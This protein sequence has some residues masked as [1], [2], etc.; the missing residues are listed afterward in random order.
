VVLHRIDLLERLHVVLVG[1][2]W[3]HGAMVHRTCFDVSVHGGG[4]DRHVVASTAGMM[5]MMRISI[6][7][8]SLWFDG[9]H[10]SCS[11]YKR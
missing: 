9:G 3:R 11:K 5:K 10:A 2:T 8:I 1:G 7:K 4:A 6:P